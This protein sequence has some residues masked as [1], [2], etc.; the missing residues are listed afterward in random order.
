MKTGRRAFHAVSAML[1]VPAFRDF[2]EIFKQLFSE[3]RTNGFRMELDSPLWPCLVADSHDGT[4][5][6]TGCYGECFRKIV[7]GERMVS[8]DPER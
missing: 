7:C 3:I 2:S 5:F 4:V 1:S 6:C 8:D